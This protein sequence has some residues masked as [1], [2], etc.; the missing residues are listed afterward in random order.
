LRALL[1]GKNFGRRLLRGASF[2]AL[3]GKLGQPGQKANKKI[4]L[5]PEIIAN[6]FSE[7]DF[8]VESFKFP[9]QNR[10]DSMGDDAREML[11]L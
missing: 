11:F 9:R 8:V 2:F 7:L 10:K 6:T 1:R 5:V 4:N 3:H